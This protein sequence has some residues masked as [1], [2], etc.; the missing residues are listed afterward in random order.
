MDFDRESYHDLA[1]R[2]ESVIMALER[3]KNDVLII[4]HASV[5]RCLVG[6]L[7]DQDENETPFIS[8]PRSEVIEV[9]PTAYK[10]KDR[11]LKI[12]E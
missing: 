11:R 1:I 10:S 12:N 8:I 3:E 4:A 2:L 5:L 7:F 9:T 6:Y